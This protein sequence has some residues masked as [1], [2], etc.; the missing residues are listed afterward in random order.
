MS[1]ET[2]KL[3]TVAVVFITAIIVMI[4]KI[5]EFASTKKKAAMENPTA[6]MASSS[7]KQSRH[8]LISELFLMAGIFSFY[9]YTSG[10][11]A[12]ATRGD[13]GLLSFVIL[14]MIYLFR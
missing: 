12:P 11:S 14:S 4:T 8:R 7:S 10:S 6:T 13:L 2:I 9:F 3:L 5:V 1:L